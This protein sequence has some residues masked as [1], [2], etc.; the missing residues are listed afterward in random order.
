MFCIFVWG[1]IMSFSICILQEITL[2]S[3]KV[4]LVVLS[5]DQKMLATEVPSFVKTANIAE[6]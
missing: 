2:C 6:K 5:G 4:I 1:D 3:L